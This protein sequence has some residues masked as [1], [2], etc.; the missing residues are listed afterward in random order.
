MEIRAGEGGA[1]AENFVEE[2]SS[3]IE[4]HSGVSRKNVGNVVIFDRL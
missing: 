2:F 1:D 4:K 3:A